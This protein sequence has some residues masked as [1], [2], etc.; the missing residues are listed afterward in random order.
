MILAL[1]IDL[2]HRCG[3]ARVV[4]RYEANRNALSLR[5]SDRELNARPLCRGSDTLKPWEDFV[6]LAATP[7]G[8]LDS[9]NVLLD[10]QHVFGYVC[11]RNFATS[12]STAQ[13]TLSPCGVG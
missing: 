4:A 7:D 5:E 6:Q 9:V 8:A 11:L 10:H 3:F 12:M 2:A 13:E 1:E